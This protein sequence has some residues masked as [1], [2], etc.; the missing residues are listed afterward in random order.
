MAHHTLPCRLVK[1]G[2]LPDHLGRRLTRISACGELIGYCASIALNL[3]RVVAIVEREVLL[4]R[5]LER[6]LQVQ[7]MGGAL[8][9]CCR[10]GQSGRGG[11]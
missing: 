3:L 6:R 1:V 8:E 10:Q 5:E 7:E 9:A 2:L 4:M 11:A